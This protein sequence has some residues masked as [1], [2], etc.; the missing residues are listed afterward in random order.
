[1]DSVVHDDDLLCTNIKRRP[2]VTAET[3]ALLQLLYS[4]G[5]RMVHTS[6]RWLLRQF[7]VNYQRSRNTRRTKN[8]FWSKGRHQ[9]AYEQQLQWKFQFASDLHS[10]E[11]ATVSDCD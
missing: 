7:L 2:V 1:M 5:Y 11:Y 3:F 10:N 9:S 6:R 8:L 4:V